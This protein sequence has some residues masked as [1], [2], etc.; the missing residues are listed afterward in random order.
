MSAANEC[1]INLR[2]LRPALYTGQR[3]HSRECGLEFFQQEKRE[4]LAWY[5]RFRAQQVETPQTESDAA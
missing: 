1:E 3:F 4:A 2:E 5:R